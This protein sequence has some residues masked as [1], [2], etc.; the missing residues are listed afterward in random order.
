MEECFLQ[1]ELMVEIVGKMRIPEEIYK[2]PLAIAKLM[3]DF[4]EI[5]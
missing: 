2:I 1:S 3:Q 5:Q 4:C